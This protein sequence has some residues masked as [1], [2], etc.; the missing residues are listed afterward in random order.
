MAAGSQTAMRRRISTAHDDGGMHLVVEGVADPV[1]A[2]EWDHDAQRLARFMG[3][4]VFGSG[5]E[6]EGI[7]AA[8]APDILFLVGAIDDNQP[9]ADTFV[10]ASGANPLASI[11]TTTSAARSEPG[12]QR[13]ASTSN[14]VPRRTPPFP[15]NLRL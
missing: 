13:N 3:P 2:G 9:V 6:I 4:A 11:A 14:A 12:A 5:E 7:V 1:I 10:T 15:S 8:L